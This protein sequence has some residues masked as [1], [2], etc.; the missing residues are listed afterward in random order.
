MGWVT[1]RRKCTLDLAFADIRDAVEADVAEANEPQN[2][3][4]CQD[5]RFDT[6]N[7]G[8]KRFM[9]MG[10]PPERSGSYKIMF[11]LHGDHIRI[12]RDGPQTLP[13]LPTLVVRQRWDFS[14]SSCVLY[15]DVKGKDENVCA[16][17]VSQM[18]LE[19]VFF[20]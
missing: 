4:S 16:Q 9:V 7:N 12:T 15:V 8:H 19:P 1:E 2:A 18:A 3:G 11:E 10:R 13:R 6:G 17:Q 5:A 20:G 14:T